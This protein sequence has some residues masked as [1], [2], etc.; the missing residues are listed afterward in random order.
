VAVHD[1]KEVTISERES[2]RIGLAKNK[3]RA[4]TLLYI[5]FELEITKGAGRQ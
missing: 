3:E 4:R 1:G 2:Y 5:I